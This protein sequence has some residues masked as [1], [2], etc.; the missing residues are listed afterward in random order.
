MA[1]QRPVK[2][3]L[4]VLVRQVARVALLLRQALVATVLH[5]LDW[6]DRQV[7]ALQVAAR[8]FVAAWALDP[9]AVAAVAAFMAAVVVT[10]PAAAADHLMVPLTLQWH[11][12]VTQMAM[13]WLWCLPYA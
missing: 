4:H 6:W 2:L 8:V 13:A 1:E 7:V 10:G 5:V 3:E 11:A 9:Q 12:D